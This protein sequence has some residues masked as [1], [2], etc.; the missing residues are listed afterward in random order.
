MSPFEVIRLIRDYKYFSQYSR[1]PSKVSS[2]PLA[3]SCLPAAPP[4]PFLLS[5]SSSTF[6]LLLSSPL[7]LPPFSS[8]PVQLWPSEPL[9]VWDKDYSTQNPPEFEG[10]EERGE[11]RSS[12]EVCLIKRSWHEVFFLILFSSTGCLLFLENSINYIELSQTQDIMFIQKG[13]D[14]IKVAYFNLITIY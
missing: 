8:L 6:L 2:W 11:T 3:L 7:H 12:V 9:F 10:P 1:D 4:V 5:S 13:L 14:V